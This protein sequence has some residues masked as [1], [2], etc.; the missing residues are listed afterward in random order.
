MTRVELSAAAALFL[1]GSAP[2]GCIGA[3]ALAYD[4]CGSDASCESDPDCPAEPPNSG[5]KCDLADNAE[6]FYCP[7]NERRDVHV[8]ECGSG[9]WARRSNTD[10]N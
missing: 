1:F 7:E 9:R 4:L 8:Y 3:E 5:V 6:C 2:L 10:C